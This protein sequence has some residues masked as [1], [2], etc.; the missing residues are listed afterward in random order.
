MIRPTFRAVD[1]GRSRIVLIGTPRYRDERLADVPVV[2]NNVADLA[3]A[4]TDPTLGGFAPEHCR[5]V[6]E[7]ADLVQIG[8]VLTAAAEQASDLLLVY[9]SG[10]GLIDR[11]GKLYLSLA[12]TRPDQL[13]YSALTFDAVRETFLDSPASN[14]VLIL[15]SCFSGRAIG[16]PLAGEEQ[17]LL[18]ALEVSGT[19]T[20][21]AATANRAALILDGERHTAFTERLLRLLQDGSPRAG[22]MLTLTDIYRH[23]HAQLTAEG[24]P[25]PQQRGTNTAEMLGLVHNRQVVT[26]R[27]LLAHEALPKLV[28]G[29]VTGKPAA[30]APAWP[31]LPTTATA[32]AED[33]IAPAVEQ[34]LRHVAEAGSKQLRRICLAAVAPVVAA[35]AEEQALGI[36]ATLSDADRRHS[37]LADIAVVVAASDTFRAIDILSTVWEPYRTMALAD[38]ART[39]GLRH[40]DNGA[41]IL[42]TY[43]LDDTRPRRLGAD[44]LSAIARAVAA[45][46]PDRAEEIAA[47]I[48]DEYPRTVALAGIA[49]TVAV[50]DP[51]RA[52]RLIP[53]RCGPW[54]VPAVA[55]AL[56]VIDPD[57]ALSLIAPLVG[58]RPHPLAL[59][60][61]ARTL[62]A[63]DPHRALRIACGITDRARRAEALAAVAEVVAATS[64]DHAL[65]IT[66]MIGDSRMEE[67][68]LADVAPVV[69]AKDPQRAMDI[70]EGITGT[71]WKVLALAGIASVQ[72]E[73]PHR[74]RSA[75]GLAAR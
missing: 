21:T 4:F 11:R 43:I 66:R 70:A 63:T 65:E 67:A 44:S 72:L 31:G 56:A 49:L 13:A 32:P 7:D 74:R 5:R 37:V 73:T 15:D 24:L 58:Q 1:P 27:Q 3:R 68:A 51:G 9:Y 29:A 36:A 71:L 39:D 30:I 45:F 33:R 10:H 38:I 47:G 19:F 34:A 53:D 14:R 46:A 18:T 61:V 62:A 60:G 25:V 2:A 41:Y 64:L 35:I 40:P 23:L 12:G 69:A 22:Q 59:I 55:E 54:A 75:I 8:E 52:L 28:N 26:A 42:D 50:T 17:S 6:S 57:R 48:S 16:Q 20:L